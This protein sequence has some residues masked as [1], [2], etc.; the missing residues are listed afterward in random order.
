MLPRVWLTLPRLFELR[1]PERLG[2][3]QLEVLEGSYVRTQVY[4]GSQ[5]QLQAKKVEFKQ[6]HRVSV[7][8]YQSTGDEPLT[9][10]CKVSGG[11]LLKEFWHE[12]GHKYSRRGS[13]ITKLAAMVR[14][15]LLAVYS[16]TSSNQL[17]AVC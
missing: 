11:A 10:L 7:H 17:A 4:L 16:W 15:M 5:L 6:N 12:R 14:Y 9:Y 1:D 8:F 2:C 13:Q 3:R